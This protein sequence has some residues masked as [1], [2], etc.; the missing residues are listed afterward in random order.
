MGYATRSQVY[1]AVDRESFFDDSSSVT[2]I[3]IG[4]TTNTS[5][6]GSQ[7]RKDG[8]AIIKERDI[9]EEETE[10]LFVEGYLRARIEATDKA[11]RFR[12]DYFGC[13]KIDAKWFEEQ[14][15]EWV[16]E[17]KRILTLMKMGLPVSCN[18]FQ[19]PVAPKGYEELFET[20]LTNLEEN[21]EFHLT[22]KCNNK[23]EL[24]YL[25]IFEKSF[26][27]FGYRCSAIR[28]ASWVHFYFES[29]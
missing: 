17:A 24:E 9:N 14:F 28:E 21:C 3:K 5:R 18:G 4:E 8:F 7:L 11:K 1:F 13:K 22:V 29:I 2:G 27:P 26:I 6:R 19:K 23:R 15:D 12:R 10:R 16:N 25:N 20:I